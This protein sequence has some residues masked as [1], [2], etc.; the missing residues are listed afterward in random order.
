MLS[1]HHVYVMSLDFF[2]N[3]SDIQRMFVFNFLAC[4]SYL[5]SRIVSRDMFSVIATST[6]EST[7]LEI[8]P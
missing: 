1:T 6:I 3:I 7:C 5:I 2:L 8:S 4:P